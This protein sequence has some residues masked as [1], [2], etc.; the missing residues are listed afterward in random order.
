M[1]GKFKQF[2]FMKNAILKIKCCNLP[3]DSLK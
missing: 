1:Q 2:I 3:L